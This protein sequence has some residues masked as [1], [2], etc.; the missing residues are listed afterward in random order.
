MASMNPSTETSYRKHYATTDA[1]K[2]KGSE[3]VASAAP[4]QD[5][6]MLNVADAPDRSKNQQTVSDFLEEGVINLSPLQ[7]NRILQECAYEHQR[8]ISERHM[9]VLADLMARGQWQAKSQ[10]DFAVLNGQFILINGYHRAYAQ[11][12]S[13]KTIQWSVAFH[14]AK[15]AADLRTLYFAFDTNI[16]IRGAREILRASEFADVHGLPKEMADTLYRAVP[17][18]ASGFATNPKDKKFLVEKSVDRRLALAAEYAKPAARYAACLEGIA[19]HRKAKFRGG[20]IAA[21]AIITFKYQN[22]TAWRFWT[23]VANNDGLKRGDPRSAL[24]T[25]MLTRKVRAGTAD[26]FA[27]AMIAWNAFFEEREIKLIK[28]LDSFKPCIEGTPFNGR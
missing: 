12:R 17:F 8:P 14:K 23:G 11:V 18:I 10:I 3:A 22:E 1:P 13:G 7:M 5:F 26:S 25:D 4:I 2:G 15:S 20:A 28:V 9:L 27:P 16:R 24:I 19:A 21:V 6:A